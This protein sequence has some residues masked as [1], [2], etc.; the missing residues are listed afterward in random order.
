MNK[1]L[2]IADLLKNDHNHKINDT[3]DEHFYVDYR[4]IF[5]SAA[6]WK[7]L[8]NHCKSIKTEIRNKLTPQSFEAINFWKSNRELW[9]Y[10]QELN[11]RA[12]S[13]NKIENFRVY[14]RMEKDYI[15]LKKLNLLVM[16]KYSSRFKV[17]EFVLEW[18]NILE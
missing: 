16:L 5:G 8:F 9:E 4:F 14:K 7:G 2:G 11:S 15:Y 17:D 6:R 13:M 10:L 12:I 1:N 18:V 3:K